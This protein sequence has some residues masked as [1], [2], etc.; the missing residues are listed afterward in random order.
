MIDN[1]RDQATDRNG[2]SIELNIEIGDTGLAQYIVE[3]VPQGGGNPI[4]LSSGTTSICDH[5]ILDPAKFANGFYTLRVTASDFGGL[6]TIATSELEINSAD[7]SGVVN[8]SSTDLSATL[9]GIDVDITRFYSSLTSSDP[10]SNFG[11]AWSWPLIDPQ[12]AVGVDTVDPFAGYVDGTRL[13]LTL[14][15]GE[16]VGYTFAPTEL[17]AAAS[18][19][20]TFQPAWTADDGVTWS[21]ESFARRTAPQGWK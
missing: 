18:G 10:D 12:I 17:T 19:V 7:K 21:L 1:H 5:I 8:E 9:A 4:R 13:Y 16:R 2:T 20:Q 14:P 11:S 6:E 15:T 3:L